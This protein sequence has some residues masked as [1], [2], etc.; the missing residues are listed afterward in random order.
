MCNPD[1]RQDSRVLPFAVNTSSVF[2]E[3][4][5]V[6]DQARAQSPLCQLLTWRS[7]NKAE[8]SYGQ[9]YPEGQLLRQW[10]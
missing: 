9:G 4:P 2:T 6:T 5:R 10:N 3:A 8:E 1:S 7:F